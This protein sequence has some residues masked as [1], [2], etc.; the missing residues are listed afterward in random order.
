MHMQPFMN[1]LYALYDFMPATGK[2]LPVY[3]GL[4]FIRKNFPVD[5]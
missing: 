3:D 1:L 4:F 2:W 5:R